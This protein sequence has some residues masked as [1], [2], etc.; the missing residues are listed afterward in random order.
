MA[1]EDIAS[2]R[3][4]YGSVVLY[5]SDGNQ[6]VALLDLMREHSGISYMRTTRSATPT[7]YEPGESFAIG[8]SR[9]V[10]SSEADEITL[11]A[12]GITLHEALAA[13]DQLAEQGRSARVI[14]L[15]SVKPVDTAAILAAAGETRA[16]ITIEDHWAEGGIGETVAGVLA[17]AGAATPLTRLAVSERPT[18]GPPEALL[19]AAGI[20]ADAIVAAAESAL[21]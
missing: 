3:A 8:G 2:L 12:A 21:G 5:P 16:L 18:S 19:A 1:L 14:D 17:E 20:D 13:A 9:T 4:V 11:I 6:A 15:Y 10:R 7:I